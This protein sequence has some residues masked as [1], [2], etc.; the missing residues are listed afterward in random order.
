MQSLINGQLDLLLG[1]EDSGEGP[2]APGAQPA[3]SPA[4]RAPTAPVPSAGSAA[5]ATSVHDQL[6][7]LDDLR[8]RGI[9]SESEFQAKKTELLKRL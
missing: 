9:L 1:V 3:P 4:R 5:P 7:E 8:Q 2:G 6:I